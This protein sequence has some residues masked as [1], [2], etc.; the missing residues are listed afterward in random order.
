MPTG[1]ATDADLS[2]IRQLG[3]RGVRVTVRQ[4]QVWRRL[5]IISNPV[6]V[7]RGRGRGTESVGYPKGTADEVQRVVDLLQRLRNLDWVVIALFGAGGDPSERAVRDSYKVFIDES[8]AEFLKVLKLATDNKDAYSQQVR[9]WIRKY[10]PEYNDFLD[11]WDA[12]AREV[13]AAESSYE[14]P[15]TER[16]SRV[17]KKEIRER[18]VRDV[19]EW[20]LGF[21]DTTPALVDTFGLSKADREMYESNGGLPRFAELRDVARE[22]HFSVLVSIRDIVRSDL[23]RDAMVAM[24][25]LLRRFYEVGLDD[26]A[27]S[28]P[29][30]AYKVLITAAMARRDPAKAEIFLN[31]MPNSE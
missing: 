31:G 10:R 26:P 11:A 19:L 7:R 12:Q 1:R 20:M 23:Y 15:A 22:T 5:G 25:P 24:P 28:G 21:G 16:R 18:D 6:V 30:N 17:G 8:E 9:R 13:A 27:I 2:L 4:L 29:N 14:D 3:E